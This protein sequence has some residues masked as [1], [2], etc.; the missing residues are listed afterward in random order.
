M[1]RLLSH[2]NAPAFA[3]TST[4]STFTTASNHVIMSKP[5]IITNSQKISAL[6]NS[7]FYCLPFLFN[8]IRT[9]VLLLLLYPDSSCSCFILIAPAPALSP[10]LFHRQNRKMIKLA[11]FYPTRILHCTVQDV[12]V[13]CICQFHNLI[14]LSIPWSGPHSHDCTYIL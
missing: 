12:A 11:K 10:P 7:C 3:Y 13:S 1:S 4:I 9:K 14:S 8:S 5:I 6:D 2:V